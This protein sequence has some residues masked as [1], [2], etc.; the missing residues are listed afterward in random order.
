MVRILNLRPHRVKNLWSGW[1]IHG[2]ITDESNRL[3]RFHHQFPGFP[4]ARLARWWK[5]CLFHR[6][7]TCG[8]TCP[9]A[10]RCCGSCIFSFFTWEIKLKTFKNH[11]VAMYRLKLFQDM[12]IKG[13]SKDWAIFH[14]LLVATSLL[15]LT[16]ERAWQML[17]P[18]SAN[19][20]RPALLLQVT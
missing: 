15:E 14:S 1:S 2:S 13:V 9:Q 11:Y 17:E 7:W 20:P 19:S 8:L 12:V 6:C 10:P 4:A 18:S 3:P 5:S 16:R